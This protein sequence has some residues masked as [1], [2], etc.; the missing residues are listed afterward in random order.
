LSV[1][2]PAEGSYRNDDLAPARGC[3]IGV[4]IGA[5][6]WAIIIEGATLIVHAVNH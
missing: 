3:L 6:L 1:S 4:L 5:G 2:R